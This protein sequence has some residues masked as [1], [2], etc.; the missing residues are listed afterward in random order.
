MVGALAA[1]HETGQVELD[2]QGLVA[3]AVQAPVGL[4]RG[5]AERAGLQLR[6]PQIAFGAHMRP[7]PVC[8]HHGGGRALAR[9]PVGQRRVKPHQRR[10]R[11]QRVALQ[12]GPPAVGLAVAGGV[13]TAI[14]AD[15]VVAQLNV[16]HQLRHG[17]RGGLGV[18]Q[19]DVGRYRHAGQHRVMHAQR[20]VASQALRQLEGR[21]VGNVG[22][23]AKV[24]PPVCRQPVRALAPGRTR[25]TGEPRLGVEID[26]GAGGF[27]LPVPAVAGVTAAAG[28]GRAGFAH[29]LQQRPQVGRGV[30]RRG[31]QLGDFEALVGGVAFHGQL[32]RLGCGVQRAVEVDLPAQR[33]AG[34][35]CSVGACC[36]RRRCR[37]RCG[38]RRRGVAPG[39]RQSAQRGLHRARQFHG[40]GPAVQALR[41]H[42]VEPGVELQFMALPHRAAD[43]AAGR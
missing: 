31:T 22:R 34:L 28:C 19:L 24:E 26:Q 42:G 20:A 27:E 23:Q 17:R 29:P 37:F 32:H 35:A 6:N 13:A 4:G 5:H 36:A 3:A 18:A 33:R 25:V 1:K 43:Q 9:R 38:C 41:R 40:R 14:D 15:A 8:S 39:R 11:R 2:R 16:A 7:S 12:F 10:Q 30:A 21:Q